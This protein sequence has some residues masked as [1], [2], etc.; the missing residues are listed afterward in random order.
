MA[1]SRP[2]TAAQGSRRR[3]GERRGATARWHV[4]GGPIDPRRDNNSG[5]GVVTSTK[6]DDAMDSMD[7]G[8]ETSIEGH[9]TYE[10]IV[11][12][13][14][15]ISR[16]ERDVMRTIWIARG[17]VLRFSSLRFSSLLFSS[18][19]CALS[20][21]SLSSG[22]SRLGS[23][24]PP[25]PT[26]APMSHFAGRSVTTKGLTYGLGWTPSGSRCRHATFGGATGGGDGAGSSRPISSANELI[27]LLRRDFQEMPTHI[28][29]VTHDHTLTQDQLRKVQGQLRH[30]K[31]VL[32][33]KLEISFTPAPPR[34][35]PANE[36]KTDND[37]DD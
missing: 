20:L 26:A 37:L 23:Q 4:A 33:D 19:S 7:F 30:M 28:L 29:H 10:A 35:V 22:C 12:C 17:E 16:S 18:I 3:R 6:L 27:E 5:Q 25:T 9:W 1:T 32:M 13:R 36:S 31:Q 8:L 15:R 11:G 24:P 34:D 2:R 14:V 21:L